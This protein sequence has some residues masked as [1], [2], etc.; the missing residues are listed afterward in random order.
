MTDFVG[1]SNGVG[2]YLHPI[3]PMF[4]RYFV[5]KATVNLESDGFNKRAL[6]LR[7]ANQ[8][9]RYYIAGGLLILV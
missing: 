8:L 9:T 7:Y 6:G 2:I 4:L 1:H 5:V 3:I